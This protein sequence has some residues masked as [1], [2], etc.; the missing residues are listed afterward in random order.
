MNKKEVLSVLNNYNFPKNDFI[1]LSGAAMVLMGIKES[2]NDIDIGVSKKFYNQL[3]K[4]HNCKL[5]KIDK[6]GA[7]IYFIDDVI[8]FG[9]RYFDTDYLIY[10]GYR[11][12]TPLA[13][14]QLKQ[15]LNRDKDK[16]DI[17]LI[18]KYLEEHNG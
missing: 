5:E 12:Q 7:K 9:S 2:T 15:S 4:D 11:L 1:I 6:D 14:K 3:L 17:Y 13:I 8:N 16:N 18:D 10:E